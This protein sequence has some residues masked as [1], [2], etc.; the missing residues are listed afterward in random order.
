MKTVKLYATRHFDL[1]NCYLIGGKNTLRKDEYLLTR[2]AVSDALSSP[3][4]KPGE[5]REVFIKVGRKVKK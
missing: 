3:G 2:G 5:T 1:P 4:F